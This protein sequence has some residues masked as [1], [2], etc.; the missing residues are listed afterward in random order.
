[1]YGGDRPPGNGGGNHAGSNGKGGGDRSSG[2]L[3]S[4]I[5]GGKRGDAKR[6]SGKPGGSGRPSSSGGGGMGRNGGRGGRI[7][8]PS[9]QT[10][11]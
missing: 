11:T 3:R 7:R 5:G 2:Y 9:L 6:M 10:A 4:I 8:N 1:M